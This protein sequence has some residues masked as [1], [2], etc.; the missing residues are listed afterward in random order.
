MVCVLGI[1]KN[2]T[3]GFSAKGCEG[4][5]VVVLLENALAKRV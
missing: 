4:E 3:K 5:D 2:W 1:L